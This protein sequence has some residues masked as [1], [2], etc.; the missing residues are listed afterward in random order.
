MN[1]SP[2][3]QKQINQFVGN[4]I[5]VEIKDGRLAIGTLSFYNWEQQVIH[6]SD[7]ELLKP[8]P[9]EEGYSKSTGEILI[10]NCRDWKTLQV[11]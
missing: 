3:D 1:R 10:V 4:K 8:E 7:Y 9:D 2:K 5:E 11:R 6:V